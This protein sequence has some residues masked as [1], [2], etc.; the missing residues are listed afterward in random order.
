MYANGRTGELELIIIAK[1]P[2]ES[3]YIIGAL[4]KMSGLHGNS[5]YNDP[6]FAARLESIASINNYSLR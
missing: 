6:Y 2:N 3:A 1:N 5:E 4:R